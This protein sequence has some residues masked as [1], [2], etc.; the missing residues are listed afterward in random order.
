MFN[1]YYLKIFVHNYSTDW[2]VDTAKWYFLNR[3]MYQFIKWTLFQVRIQNISISKFDDQSL[4]KFES[5]EVNIDQSEVVP[6]M[7]PSPDL[8]WYK[9]KTPD[10]HSTDNTIVHVYITSDIALVEF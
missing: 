10:M 3:F 2:L 8:A 9:Y 4:F 6:D 1:V 7:S 5:V